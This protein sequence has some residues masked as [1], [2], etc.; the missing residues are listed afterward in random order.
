MPT[1]NRA[2]LPKVPGESMLFP[3]LFEANVEFRVDVSR[4]VEVTYEVVLVINEDDVIGLYSQ[5]IVQILE[6]VTEEKV[7]NPR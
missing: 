3:N 4:I 5:R 6:V 1:E 2:T 7:R